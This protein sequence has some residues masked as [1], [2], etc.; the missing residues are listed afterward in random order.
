MSKVRNTVD[1]R[2]K[3]SDLTQASRQVSTLSHLSLNLVS[4]V[5]GDHFTTSLGLN[6]ASEDRGVP[7][8]FPTWKQMRSYCIA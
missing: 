5:L 2:T 1:I 3:E 8:E 7:I 4:P 6:M